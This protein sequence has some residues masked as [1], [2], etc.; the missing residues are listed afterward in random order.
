MRSHG[1]R[2]VGFDP[3]DGKRRNEKGDAAGPNQA[4]P[5]VA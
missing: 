1:R 4:S 5:T 2:R 3:D